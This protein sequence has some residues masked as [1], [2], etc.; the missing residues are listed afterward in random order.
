MSAQ[1]GVLW[2]RVLEDRSP[3]R[4]FEARRLQ[5]ELAELR[6]AHAPLR[7]VT[8]IKRTG[9]QVEVA[10]IAASPTRSPKAVAA[11]PSAGGSRVTSWQPDPW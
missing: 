6:R 1:A 10:V 9:S 8:A 2:R 5:Q 7:L 3:T 11:P 4:R